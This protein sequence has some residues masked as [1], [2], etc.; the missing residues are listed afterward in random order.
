MMR[1]YESWRMIRRIV[2]PPAFPSIVRPFAT[3]RSK[4]VATQDERA[5][6]FHCA[7]GERVIKASFPAFFSQHLTKSPRW[8]KP[9]EDLL[10]SQTKRMI[11]TLSASRSEAIKR[12]A[13]PG[14]F[15]FGH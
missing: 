3:H 13:E 9:L 6:T 10:A 12:D 2:T 4:H 7:S 1:Q 5:E 11:Q 14:N 15:Y 8:E